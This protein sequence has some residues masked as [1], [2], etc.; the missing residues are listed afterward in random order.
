MLWENDTYPNAAFIRVYLRQKGLGW[1]WSSHSGVSRKSISTAV[2]EMPPAAEN[3]VIRSSE[4]LPPRGAIGV[5]PPPGRC[6]GGALCCQP[7]SGDGAVGP[8]HPLCISEEVLQKA[9]RLCRGRKG[10]SA[11]LSRDAQEE[12]EAAV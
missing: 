2:R 1:D 7:G 5:S 12:M 8:Q 11:G 9:L 4:T 6:T 10:S 3:A